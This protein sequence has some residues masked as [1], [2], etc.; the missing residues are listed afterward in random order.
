MNEK[1][2]KVVVYPMADGG[3]N[4]FFPTLM[5]PYSEYN[6]QL[7][8]RL[9]RHAKGITY[10]ELFDMISEKGDMLESID[11]ATRERLLQPFPDEASRA[12]AIADVSM[13]DGYIVPYFR[14]R[15]TKID[16]SPGVYV[17]VY[18]Y[19]YMSI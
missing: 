15:E 9:T 6:Y 18:M 2:Q 7:H 13:A 17:N 1:V 10:Y 8:K 4:N 12:A 14:A 3:R 11:E 16:H 5:L 19:A